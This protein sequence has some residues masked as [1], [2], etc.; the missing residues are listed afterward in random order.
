MAYF[1]KF[2][3]ELQELLALFKKEERWLIIINAD[4]D[5][6]ASAMA[7][8]RIMGRKVQEVGIAHINEVKR[9]DNLAMIHYLRI[10]ARRVIPTLLA[11]YDKFAIVDSQPHHH[12][13][14]AHIKFSV[15]IDHHPF[16]AEPYTEAEYSD[17]RP[18]YGSN[19][20]MMTEYLYNMKIRPA[21]LLA[22][23]LAYGI[24]TDTQSFERPFID[25]DIKAFRYLTKYADMDIIKRIMRSEIHPDWLKYFS[26]AFYNLRRIGPGLYSHLGKVENPDTLV[27]LADF[28]MRVHDVSWDVVSGIYDD[29]LVVIF[30]GDGLRKDMGNMASS[31]FS[32][33]GSAGGHT[34][35]A[36]A[37][38]PLKA[39]DGADPEGFVIKKLTKGK[40]RA[41][42]RV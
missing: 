9:L 14:F 21:K 39:L 11:Q 6:L 35:A 34:A 28:F 27:I 33:I 32:E 41:I 8:K 1:K 26:R 4:P 20:A 29:T 23:A 19:S 36:R 5:S 13:D 16:A 18:E 22:T 15:I 42:S 30:R 7:L 40:R 10:P 31:L 37:E 17:I 3:E 24:K 2:D 12:P 38:I 25:A